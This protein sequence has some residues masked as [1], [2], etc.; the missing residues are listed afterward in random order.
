MEFVRISFQPAAENEES[1]RA[2]VFQPWGSKGPGCLDD[3]QEQAGSVW[4]R[5]R[6][7]SPRQHCVRLGGLPA[8]C[9]GT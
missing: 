8:F 1:T 7:M 5:E 2:R 9:S 6:R 4:V 3:I